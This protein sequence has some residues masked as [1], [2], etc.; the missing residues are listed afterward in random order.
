MP[1][2]TNEDRQGHLRTTIQV[3]PGER[4]KLC[5]CMRSKDMPFCDSTHKSLPDTNAGPVIVEV[6]LPEKPVDPPNPSA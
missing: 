2:I 6:S 3:G 4:L 5:R 1:L